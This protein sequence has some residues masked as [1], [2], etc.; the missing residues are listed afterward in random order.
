MNTTSI[1]NGGAAGHVTSF[2]KQAAT[3]VSMARRVLEGVDVDTI[4]PVLDSLNIGMVN[5]REALRHGLLVHR[6]H[7]YLEII[8]RVPG[9]FERNLTLLIISSVILAG[10]VLILL[11]VQ[12]SNARV[13]K[14]L[15]SINVK[16]RYDALHDALTGLPNRRFVEQTLAEPFNSDGHRALFHID[17]DRFKHIN[18]TLGHKAGDYVLCAVADTLTQ[19]LP[20]DGFAA[21]IGGD[22]FLMVADFATCEG[23]VK[24]GEK[25]VRELEKPVSF[26]NHLCRFGA[27]V[28][29]AE[30]ETEEGPL[31][32]FQRA[33][34]ALNRAKE[35]GRGRAT[36]FTPLLGAQFLDEKALADEIAWG[37]D[38]EEFVPYF[39]PQI[40]TQTGEVIGVEALARWQHPKRGV[41]APDMF[42]AVAERMGLVSEIDR[43]ILL[44]SRDILADW[45]KKGIELPQLSVNTSAKRLQVECLTKGLQTLDLGETRLC[46]ELL[47]SI[48]LDDTNDPL[49]MRVEELRELGLRVEIDDFGT[50]HASIVSLLRLNPDGFKIARELISPIERDMGML[51]LVR[52]II[53][54]GK[55]LE[56]EIVA[57]GVETAGQINLLHGLGCDVLQGYGIC[58]PGPADEIAEFIL[59]GKR[60][61]SAVA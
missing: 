18:D 54:M 8:E 1:K 12:F 51:Q 29:I 13:Q 61:K 45:R 32:L 44:A 2:Q 34:I 48:F 7:G 35:K 50:G 46:F 15:K 19:L 40:S 25:V 53:E 41:L 31:D 11:P 10:V 37:L 9:F 38:N 60:Q 27:S 30:W 28:G 16:L 47:E 42:L 6:H 24:L 17:L 20:E 43:A 5:E 36:L 58:R 57:E 26:E 3:V 55:S 59:N 14:V 22:E 39:Q 33:D 21:R 4:P 52:S 56:M 23:A 49:I